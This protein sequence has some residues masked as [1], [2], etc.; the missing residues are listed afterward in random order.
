MSEIQT[1][2]VDNDIL[3]KLSGVK[4]A[5]S[6]AFVN[7]ASVELT[8]KDSAGADLGGISWPL[9]MNYTGT[10]GEYSALVDKAALLVDKEGYTAII[11]AAT[12]GNVD[13]HW[14]IPLGAETR[15]S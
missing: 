7:D 1:V 5:S 4:L 10:D 11:D 6:G 3:I 15:D 12:P 14:E 8:I 13:G 9:G 2:Y